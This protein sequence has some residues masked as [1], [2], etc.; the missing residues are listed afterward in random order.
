MSLYSERL[1]KLKKEI[2]VEKLK[3]KKRKKKFTDNQI[4]TIDFINGLTNNATFMINGMKVVLYVGDTKKGF[5]HILE[6][7]YCSGCKGEITMLDILNFDIHLSRAMKLNE[8]GVSNNFL[9]VYYYIKGLSRY[10]IILNKE[11]EGNFVVSYY[12]VG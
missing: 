6:Q 10:K 1:A 9:D 2:A 7:H 3:R 12:H 4:L 8:E 5:K 11:S